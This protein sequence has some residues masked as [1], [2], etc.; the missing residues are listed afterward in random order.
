MSQTFV[1]DLVDIRNN[2][3][4]IHTFQRVSGV[5]SDTVIVKMWT[6][7]G[8]KSR[9]ASDREVHA[10]ACPRSAAPATTASVRLPAWILN[11]PRKAGEACAVGLA[12]PVFKGTDQEANAVEDGALAL[13]EALELKLD[14]EIDDNWT[15]LPDVLSRSRTRDELVSYCREKLQVRDRWQ[16][17]NGAGPLDLSGTLYVL[18]CMPV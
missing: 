17:K 7:W 11:V 14:I 8:G 16:D 13:A 10:V 12:G 15:A 2:T 9:A 18:V 6:K 5:I 3:A 4:D 1:K